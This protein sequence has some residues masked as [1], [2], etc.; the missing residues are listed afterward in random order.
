MSHRGAPAGR[1][2]TP[3]RPAGPPTMRSSPSTAGS[4]PTSTRAAPER[5]AA[6][7]YTANGS[8]GH[9]AEE[10]DPV[11]VRLADAGRNG[12]PPAAEFLLPHFDV[13]DAEA[14]VVEL[15]PLHDRFVVRIGA[16]VEVELDPLCGAGEAEVDPSA[17]VAHRP[18]PVHPEPE[19]PVEAE[20]A[21]EVS[22]PETA[23]DE[24]DLDGR[25]GGFDTTVGISPRAR[26]AP[27]PAD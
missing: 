7:R 19:L 21:R 24:F 23:V 15:R 4:S 2:P 9:R 17:P 25:H 10:F 16:G 11:P 8:F 20:R 26:T 3:A 27:G 14:K 22:D 1:R 5:F 18:S 12:E 6:G 13:G